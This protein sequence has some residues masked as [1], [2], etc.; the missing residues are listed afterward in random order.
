DQDH[1]TIRQLDVADDVFGIEPDHAAARDRF[2][3]DGAAGAGPGI[4]TPSDVLADLAET[5]SIPLKHISRHHRHW[6]YL[7]AA[8][9]ASALLI[10][11]SS[12][13]A[14][15]TR[16]RPTRLRPRSSCARR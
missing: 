12:S 9:F 6:L 11:E 15:S 10:T 1:L 7:P 16:T 3:H 13:P 2:L 14:S 5:G 8:R 4:T